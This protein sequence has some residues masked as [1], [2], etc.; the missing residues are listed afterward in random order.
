MPIRFTCDA[1]R[2]PLAVATRKA[3][4]EVTCP[5]CEARIRV[6]ELAVVGVAS[7]LPAPAS[8]TP[9]LGVAAPDAPPLSDEPDW[10][11]IV[12][13]VETQ[14]VQVAAPS[15]VGVEYEVDYNLISIPRRMIY[16][17]AGAIG[18]AVLFAF[19]IGYLVG[20]G[21]RGE[22]AEGVAAGE[23]VIVHVRVD[24]QE[25]V[26]KRSPDAG[27]AVIALP[28]GKLPPKKLAIAGLNPA[29]PA[30]AGT[31]AIKLLEDLGGGYAR[32][33]DQGI[34]ELLL[35]PGKY[36]VLVI[37]NR[38]VRPGVTQPKP[39]DIATLAGYFESSADLF[40][41]KKYDLSL[42][43]FPKEAPLEV[44]MGISGR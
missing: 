24:F 6:P 29:Q 13:A 23:P 4:S 19:V 15:P 17:Q 27:A 26:D 42:R 5:R 37:S 44:N 16:L 36:H 43:N 9:P 30:L 2:T 1:C 40:G 3:G 33:N 31:E 25:G 8:V 18:V 14:R 22:A 10:S 28:A 32:G 34:A 20:R 11:K 39:K 12:E 21:M 7:G 41:D 35:K 38:A